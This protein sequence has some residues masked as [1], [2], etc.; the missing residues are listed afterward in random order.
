[1]SNALNA[2]QKKAINHKTGPLLIIAG[3]GTGKTRIITEKI[4]HLI[5]KQK[6]DPQQI[7][8]VTFTEK[9]AREM[10]ERLDTVMPLG[11]EEPWLYTFHSFAD[12]ILRDE[13][14]EIGLDTSYKIIS[15]PE[16]WLLLRNNI[17]NMDLKYFL[18]L[19]NPT[20]FIS[21]ILKFISRLQDEDITPVEFRGFADSYVGEPRSEDTTKARREQKERWQELASIY[22]AYSRLKI[23]QSKMDFGDLILW[24]TKLF[25]ERPN[26]LAKYQNKFKHVLI[27]EFQDTNL[28]QYNLI[29]LLVPSVAKKDNFKDCSLIVVG[30]DSQSIYKFRGAAISNILEFR[31]DYPNAQ[32]LTLTDNYRSGQKIL[33]SAYSLIQNNNPDTLETR[34][35]ISKQ[36]KSHKKSFTQA[37]VI[38]ELATAEEEVDYTIKTI[39]EILGREPS[40]TF[41]DIAILARANNHLD[42][43]VFALRN[44]GLPYQLV[45]N[46]GL[47]D[48][49]EIRDIIALLK[50]VI[51]PTDSI[52]LYRILNIY[53]FGV[54]SD[55][56]TKVLSEARL[57]K[58]T[59]WETVNV[60]G[61]QE[62]IAL[63]EKIKA[64]QAKITKNTPLEFVFELTNDIGYI[65]RYVQDET[66]EN[67]LSINNLNIFLDRIKKFEVSHR[68]ETNSMPTII[69]FLDY[70]ELLIAAGENPAQ[71]EIEDVDT[72][73]LMTVHAS[74][75]LEFPVVFMTNLV[76]GRFPTRNR[77]DTIQIPD[78]LISEV[79]PTGNAHI[80]EER[81]LF[82]VGMTRAQKYL[83]LT[84]AKN[85]G[86]KRDTTHSGYLDE[87]KVSFKRYDASGLSK[88]KGLRNSLGHESG[89]NPHQESLFGVNTPYRAL[90]GKAVHNFVPYSLSY[91]KIE[92]YKTCG[93][94]YKYR[95]VLK[96][97]T[98]TSHALS[99]GI[100]IHDTLRDYYA[101]R[102]AG[103]P[104]TLESLHAIFENNWQPMG[105]LS[106]EHQDV[107]F[108]SGRQLL[109]DYYEKNKNGVLPVAIEKN[110]SLKFK[111]TKFFGRIDRIDPLP[112][113]GVEIVD[114]KTGRTKTQK[115]VDKDDQVSIYALAAKKALNLEPKKQ[116]YYYLESGEA[117]STTRSDTDLKKT[118]KDIEATI[119]N[120]TNGYFEPTPG[121]HCTWCEFKDVC[122]FAYK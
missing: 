114:Y 113:G 121:M 103:K 64:Y 51:D 24:C 105:Y 47:Y 72:I 46:R 27:D 30:D 79:L 15:Y 18:P 62:I 9:A 71:A 83:Y 116:T 102:L 4:K 41:R 74:K 110:F 107:R 68:R 6:V 82:Y 69:D 37:P 99:F 56:I 45:G 36:L 93:L 73:Q 117:L 8:A 115:D 81:R 53:S 17:F 16:Q 100:S 70:L 91:S 106:R 57:K 76:S 21:A 120:I 61:S 60:A 85:Y 119:D 7:L 1:M 48:R 95:Y 10:L 86:G 98:P 92:D 26:I 34:L 35:S 44:Y 63:V 88:N 38:M 109:K 32:M 5:K 52:S 54:S 118:V 40:Y 90:G 29:K 39:L 104:V 87:L 33:D 77:K 3:A 94:K 20:K 13:G 19:G 80:Q 42:P 97:P 22:E 65:K 25:K 55:D 31:K 28:A 59:L 14:L 96:I 66:L 84:W 108:K 101:K 89:Q 111:G 11:Y 23:E 49:E 58:L 112:G 75:G 12:R 2:Q 67:Q 78:E 50:V 43:F 122:P